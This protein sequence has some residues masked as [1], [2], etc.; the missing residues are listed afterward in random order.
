MIREPRRTDQG[1]I[2]QTWARSLLSVPSAG[3]PPEMRSGRNINR[4]VDAALDRVDTRGLVCC[5]EDDPNAILGWV[6][7]AEGPRVPT[8]HYLYTRRSHPDGSPARGRGI[9]S[10]LLQRVGVGRERGLV[11]T[12]SGP[13]SQFM[14]DKY[15]ASVYVPLVEFMK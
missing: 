12:S 3:R 7:F 1:Y 9:A 10:A 6:I 14:R 11:C 5:M 13:S 15:M 2:A 4:I 8:V